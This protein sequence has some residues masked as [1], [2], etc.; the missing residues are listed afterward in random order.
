MGDSMSKRQISRIFPGVI[1]LNR[2]EN[3][4]FER[5]LERDGR[6][7]AC[8]S[9]KN[10]EPHHIIPCHVYDRI[11][12]ELDNGAVLC[13]ACHDRYHGTCFPI[14][15]ETFKEFCQKNH[16]RGGRKKKK[17]QKY[18]R[19]E[20]Q[21]HPLY[22]KI[23]INDFKKDKPKKKKSKRKRRRRRKKKRTRINPIFLTDNLGTDDWDYL[24]KVQLEK[25]V[26]GDYL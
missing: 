11:Y 9:K 26:L 22:S 15:H 2:K 21:P 24:E 16:P 23:K 1:H 12:F 18:K 17:K 4:W 19:K 25:E 7:R 10:L 3:K 14:N 8:G 5:L 13:R 20:Y 6:C